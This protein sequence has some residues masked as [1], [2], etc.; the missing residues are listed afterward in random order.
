M[1]YDV[2]ILIVIQWFG[3][4]RENVKSIELISKL[5]K[6]ITFERCLWHPWKIRVACNMQSGQPNLH[7]H[8]VDW[9]YQKWPPACCI[10]YKKKWSKMNT[11]L[12]R[13]TKK[14]VDTKIFSFAYR[15]RDKA[16]FS[17]FGQFMNLSATSL[18]DVFT[19]EK[20]MTFFS[21]PW[22]SST[23]PTATFL[24]PFSSFRKDI[25]CA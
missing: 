7:R 4:F 25:T 21:S 14:M 19:A 2:Q 24:M 1:S 9:L 8:P 11:K 20:R 12:L 22:N 5:L 3:L 15:A 18:P 17:R 10:D 6:V 13:I 16:V 23:V